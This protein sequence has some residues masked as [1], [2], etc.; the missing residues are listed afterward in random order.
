MTKKIEM[1]KDEVLRYVKLLAMFGILY[2]ELRILPHYNKND[3]VIS[4]L[5]STDK[6]GCRRMIDFINEGGF[7]YGSVYSTF[8]Q[9]NVEE[10]TDGRPIKDSDITAIRFIYIDLD[11]ERPTKTSSTDKEKEHAAKLAAE[12]YSYLESMGVKSLIQFDSGNGYGLLI[13]IENGDIESVKQLNKLFVKVLDQRHSNK[14]VRVD[15]S[16]P[17]PSRITKVI[18]TPAVKGDFT[19]ERPHR[20]SFLMKIPN[21]VI[22]TPLTVLEKI[23][24]E[25]TKITALPKKQIQRTK[26][27]IIADTAIWLDSYHFEYYV[28]DGDIEGV[29]LYIF[30]ECPLKQHS[31]NQN[32]ASISVTKDGKNRFQ[33]QHASDEAK[34]IHDFAE[35]YP[36]PEEAKTLVK[37]NSKEPVTAKALDEGQKF[38]Y[39][40]YELSKKGLYY[41]DSKSQFLKI[42]DALFIEQTSIEKVTHK[43]M[44]LLC[45]FFDGEWIKQWL[46]A[47]TFQQ[48]QFKQ[49]VNIGVTFQTRRESE[50]VDYLMEQRKTAPKVY[51]HKELGWIIDD[52]HP[53]YL[54]D[55]SYS[56]SDQVQESVLS[57]E[58]FYQFDSQGTFG[59]W[60]EF[61]QLNVKH[62][63]FSLSTV[64]GFAP[65]VFGFLKTV[66]NLDIS[67]FLI[68]LRGISGSGKT[69]KLKWISSLYGNSADIIM[70]MNGTANALI[71]LSAQNYGTPVIF[72]ELGS[73]SMK[74]LTPII[75]QWASGQERLR[76]NKEM[77]LTIPEKIK[78]LLF[79]SSENA[80][81]A[82]L[83]NQMGLFSRYVE[84]SN[85][86]WTISADHA[87][88]IKAFSDQVYGV[89][90][91]QFVP[92][93]L[94]M[95][96]GEVKTLFDSVKV[97]LKQQ[98]DVDQLDQRILNNYA[99]LATTGR[100]VKK[101]LKVDLDTEKVEQLLLKTYKRS[102]EE[103][104]TASTDYYDQTVEWLLSNAH[105]FIDTSSS[106]NKSFGPIW[107]KVAVTNAQVKVNIISSI[108]KKELAKEFNVIDCDHI[109]KHLLETEK[110][111]SEKGRQTKRV[112]I[113]KENVTTFELLLPLELKDYF[114]LNVNQTIENT[115]PKPALR[116]VQLPLTDDELNFEET[117]GEN[118]NEK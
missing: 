82:Y 51:Q 39:G 28:K 77:G 7:Q 83:Q 23:V 101:L 29:K 66:L 30:K 96:S 52:N 40:N 57:K 54:L 106:G 86:R 79:L 99:V 36:V 115:E 108:F 22:D 35:Q 75:F 116:T 111:A 70:T 34:T 89:A 43:V 60:K 102:F 88:E 10:V 58:S 62:E 103:K 47:S 13:P 50:V 100:L 46:P 93:L 4:K 1:I 90:A 107:G 14:F 63:G 65:I 12:I 26:D 48:Q 20:R 87:E 113:N 32:G 27:F 98:L 45:Y 112:R 78:T 49:L 5:F 38:T 92:E 11:P 44:Y 19:E 56:S 110:M 18:G 109:I 61:V 59:E 37:N 64:L 25:N 80:L 105:R 74:D 76:M 114:K 95:D 73:A 55:K 81:K 15:V 68:S 9:F 21:E 91:K 94:K 53:V 71:K 42:A 3:K 117:E 85:I 17:N 104:R 67:V 16:V 97:E 8:N 33:C 69:T 2:I 72:D 6:E 41:L 24:K 118:K 84:F 31:N